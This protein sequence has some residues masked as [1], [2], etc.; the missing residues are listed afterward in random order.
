[1]FLAFSLSSLSQV[2]EKALFNYGE[3]RRI[4]ER[5]NNFSDRQ[6]RTSL[7]YYSSENETRSIPESIDIQTVERLLQD[8]DDIILFPDEELPPA[9]MP[10]SVY[11]RRI[12]AMPSIISLPYNE[13]VRNHIVLYVQKRAERSEYILGLAEYYMPMFEEIL[14]IYDIPLEMRALPIIESALSPVI[15]SRRGATGMW[16]FM[17]NTG[18]H[19]GLTI[20]TYVDE[21]RDF[22]ASTHAAAKYLNT[23]YT[24]FGDWTLAIAAYNCGEGTVEKAIIRA[25]RKRDYWEIYP[26]L[27]RE[28]RNYVPAFVAAN[29]LITYYKE[30]RLTP[31]K[32]INF[33]TRID[34]FMVGSRMHLEQISNVIGL[35]LSELRRLN[36]QYKK[37][38][39]PGTERPYELRIPSDFTDV[40]IEREKEIHA[41]NSKYFRSSIVINPTSETKPKR[42]YTEPPKSTDTP[43]T[44]QRIA[45]KESSTHIVGPGESLG[46]IALKY[47]VKLNDLCVWNNI[48]STTTIFPGQKLEIYGKTQRY[49]IVMQGDYFLE[50]AR[51]YNIKLDTLLKLNNMTKESKLV[52][53]QRLLLP[54]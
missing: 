2:K 1:M 15:V 17:L 10:D 20:N 40:F 7:P 28:T 36:P 44:Q 52:P 35:S 48:K 50:I 33:E 18:K 42:N 5:K 53:G 37:D 25:G 32:I 39:I 26:H 34:T 54:D 22:I 29:Y 16:Q 8:P 3:S 31:K 6:T 11:I 27:P 45:T 43:P 47:K 24:R 41:Q 14:D 49:H 38:V 13:I 19:Y 23:L 4:P 51:K 30:H 12:T 21:R 9:D 46:S